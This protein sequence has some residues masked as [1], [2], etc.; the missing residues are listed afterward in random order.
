MGFE[1]GVLSLSMF[2][3]SRK[4]ERDVIEAF[5][6]D[7][8]PPLEMLGRD[9]IHGWVTSRHLL[10]R[11]ITEDTATVA[12]RLRV[13]LAKAERKIPEALLRAECKMEEL[14]EIEVQ[15]LDFLPRAK[16]IEI[17]KEVTDRLFPN[18]PPTLTG[19]PIAY[20]GA[21]NLVY[22]GATSDKQIDAL[23]QVFKHTTGIDLIPLTPG[24]AA[25]K[26]KGRSVKDLPPTSFSPDCPDALAGESIG[27]DFLTW[28]WFFYEVHGGN[29]MVGEQPAGIMIEG[30]LTFFMQGQGA[31]QMVLRNGAPLVA[32]EA[33]T[34]LLNGKKLQ[35]AK[36]V[37]AIGEE[38]WSA[39]VDAE[40]FVMRGIKLPKGEA[41][42][43]VSRFEERMLALGRFRDLFLNMYDRFLDERLDTARWNE[44]R[45]AIHAW[46]PARTGKA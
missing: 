44:S 9:P 35:R 45:A 2:Y 46:L 11:H 26:R 36:V 31:H 5:A 4:L 6:R 23:V 33:K 41:L 24:T 38:S 12:G 25:L 7:A 28:L 18:M 34:A 43:P 10:D 37:V 30:P 40:T 16:R 32:S 19:I 3:P 14:A 17:R 29:L 42:D 39:T 8:L 1:S 27:M 20:D 22:A 15:R 21:E 13:T